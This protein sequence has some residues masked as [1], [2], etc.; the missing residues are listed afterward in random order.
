MATRKYDASRRVEAAQRTREAILAAAFRLHG[1]GVFD[2][3]SLAAEA[4]VS[5][6]TVRKHFP[7]RELL[8][9]SCTAWGMHFVELP[10]LDLIASVA[11][12]TARARVAI[13]QTYA[14][15]ESLFGQVWEAFKLEDQ[16][17]A[18]ARTVQRIEGLVDTIADLVVDSWRT[19]P[20]QRAEVKGLVVA[21]LSPLTYRAL[22]LH[23]GLTPDKAIEHSSVALVSALGALSAGAGKEAA[24]A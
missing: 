13:R 2:M 10:D 18:L 8:F 5:V 1:T 22:R 14:F 20:E 3:E 12:A 4:N 19:E 11:T 7:T 23:G 15:H 9:E 17:P 6:A 24:N 16:S 21:L